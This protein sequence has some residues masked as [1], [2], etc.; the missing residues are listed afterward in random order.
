MKG[1]VLLDLNG[2]IEDIREFRWN[3][4]DLVVQAV[5]ALAP[6]DAVRSEARAIRTM[7]EGIMAHNIP[8]FHI[9][10]WDDLVNRLGLGLQANVFS[11]YDSFVELYIRTSAVFSDAVSLLESR[12]SNVDFGIL[13]NSN[14][15][16]ARRFLQRHA[17]VD[18]VKAIVISHDTPYSKPSREVFLLAAR[19]LGRSPADLIMIGDRLDNDIMGAQQA[20]MTGVLLDRSGTIS[21]EAVGCRVISSLNEFDDIVRNP[22]HK[23]VSG[24]DP[25]SGPI[26]VIVC[27]G[28]GTRLREK[29]GNL[30]KCLAPV[31][32]K[33]ILFHTLEALMAAGLN[34]FDLISGESTAEIGEAL[35]SLPRDR[36][37][38]IRVIPIAESGTGRAVQAYWTSVRDAGRDIVYS[39]G[40][41]ILTKDTVRQFVRSSRGQRTNDV[42]LLGSPTWM[43]RTHATLIPALGHIKQI[44]A[45]PDHSDR[46][47]L[48]SVGMAY[49]NRSVDLG[50]VDLT[51]SA[52]FEEAVEALRQANRISVGYF[53]TDAPWEHLGVP[54]DWTR[55]MGGLKLATT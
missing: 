37:V 15:F 3:R 55:L 35:E 32:G 26:V 18:F 23:E 42:V 5:A 29:L 49:V 20:G 36:H 19:R 24:F 51:P 11:L 2:V 45:E 31:N 30:Q 38:R 14:S 10:F 9:M 34:Q 41:I 27:G 39:H 43:A 17:L 52:M 46:S 44:V 48:C 47:G 6:E 1:A 22:L 33:P 8:E 12:S 40:N 16:R 28:K 25:S 21:P 13:S 7:Y 54:E 4:D 50:C 53:Y